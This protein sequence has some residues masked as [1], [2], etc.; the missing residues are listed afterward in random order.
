MDWIHSY[1]NLR[2]HPK[3]RK[4][5]RR[6]GG[7]PAAVGHL[8]CLWW[9]AMDYAPD[10]DLSDHDAEDIAIG[11]EW[12]GDPNAFVTALVES[13][14]LD[15]DDDGTL[16]IHDYHDYIGRY[17]WKAEKDA[18]AKRQARAV[19]KDGE[20]AARGRRADGARRSSGR[21]ADGLARV[22]RQT[23]KTDRQTEE[24]EH[25]SPAENADDACEPDEVVDNVECTDVDV[26]PPDDPAPAQPQDD[27]DDGFEAFWALYIRKEG[28]VSA[29]RAWRRMSRTKRN[30]AFG[31]AG[32][33]SQL[34]AK[35]MS[36]PRQFIK[37]PA[38]W[39]RGEH[40]NDWRDGPPATWIPDAERRNGSHD[41]AQ[42]VRQMMAE[43]YE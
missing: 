25:M 30:L 12:E 1:K 32:V 20:P 40:W 39:L 21:R 31:I 22:D 41:L 29:E 9:W 26:L 43:G 14:F 35:G 8:H 16:S 37:T 24:K 11:C 3:T 19:E 36:P 18:A 28:K 5:A 4:L 6:V 7:L 33:M 13:G 42:T 34:H 15:R 27:G 10:G 38:A 17:Q 23:D 2:G